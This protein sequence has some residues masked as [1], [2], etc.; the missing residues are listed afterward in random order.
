MKPKRR[1][2]LLA[3][4]PTGSPYSWRQAGAHAESDP[5]L[6]FYR[7]MAKTVERGKFDLLFFGDSVSVRHDHI[8]WDRLKGSGGCNYPDAMI[9]QGVMA[10][11]TSHVGLVAT[12]STTYHE[13]YHIART[14]ATIDHL[15][16]GRAG[17][18]LV[19][20]GQKT[21]ALNFGFDEQL[22]TEARYDRAQEFLEVVL[23]L[24]DSWEDGAIVRD[25]KTKVY[26]DPQRVH[27]L[28]HVGKH[29]KV[30]G[31]LN[32]SRPP[33]G[34]PV[35][36]QAGG[37]ETGWELA[38]R[39]ADL[40]YAKANTL[41]E[42][43]KFYHQVKAR[44]DKYGRTPD[45]L[46]IMTS[47]VV[48]VGRT[49]KEA[50]E[51]ARAIRELQTETESRATLGHYIPGIDFS[52]YPMDEP[53]PDT[54]E[55]N[56]AAK[57][58]RVFLEKDGRR[59]TLRQLIQSSTGS[60]TLVGTPDQIADTMVKWLDENGTD[61]FTVTLPVLPAGL[62]EFVELVVPELQSR[63]VFRTDYERAT[64]RE[65]LGLHRPANR[66]TTRLK[67]ALPTSA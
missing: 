61:G 59:L 9:M 47:V 8:G 3:T 1:K 7:H 44:M 49:E 21:E 54:I 38:A 29:F 50:Q 32:L 31:P 19:T 14:L 36:C 37:S 26:F 46:K 2:L 48:I 20:S 41:A 33:Q 60:L 58:F 22:S 6:D 63:G 25:A 17:W 30:C 55:I 24:W 62:D 66:H 13:P 45:Q 39:T 51:N 10:T 34:H 18:N 43:R 65:N 35:L 42:G 64:L 52:S 23:D 57:R 28:N 5:D 27:T 53:L 56:Q 12:A 11:L 16:K 67:A 15:S 4:I 40:L